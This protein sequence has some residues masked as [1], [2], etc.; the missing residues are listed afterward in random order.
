MTA[1]SEKVLNWLYS[2]LTSVW[3]AGFWTFHELTRT[4]TRNITTSTR[5]SLTS[6]LRVLQDVFSKEPPVRSV[7]QERYRTPQTQHGSQGPNYPQT[8]A[9]PADFSRESPRPP[10]PPPKPHEQQTNGS[11]PSGEDQQRHSG[12]PALP[13]LPPKQP[14]R[15][16]DQYSSSSLEYTPQGHQKASYNGYHHY[17]QEPSKSAGG[18]QP[19]PKPVQKQQQQQ[20]QQQTPTRFLPE[21]A[22]FSRY[23]QPAPLPPQAQSAGGQRPA[24]GPPPGVPP[25]Q[26]YPNYPP[27]QTPQYPLPQQRGVYQSQQQAPAPQPPRPAQPAPDLLTSTLDLPL[28]SSQPSPSSHPAPPIPPNPEK[29]AL[30]HALSQTLH[31][32]LTHTLA[33][34]HA[35]IPP[36]QA[37]QSALRAAHATLAAELH[38]LQDLDAALAR[39]ER[40]LAEGMRDA[41]RVMREA[42]ERPVPGV[43]EVLVAPTV[44]GSQL[45]GLCAEE[46]GIAEAMYALGRGLDAGRVGAEAFVKQT[47]ALARERFLKKALIKKIARGMGLDMNT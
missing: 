4:L 38:Q 15:T 36:L 23:E 43:D 39:N 37:Q 25:P 18:P 13:P 33:Q 2:V 31:N 22:R 8:L 10:P 5:M 1:V 6:F 11:F 9:E 21:A 14:G 24:Q 20:Q 47:R 28:P 3:L 34:N 19:P 40:I 16:N 17:E 32:H 35:A 41:D 46:V 29:D 42:R 7:Q 12:G 26:Q 45:W 44:V 27:P 30:L